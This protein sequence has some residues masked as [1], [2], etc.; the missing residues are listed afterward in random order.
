M[1]RSVLRVGMLP[2]RRYTERP[3]DELDVSG[4]VDVGGQLTAFALPSFV[5][6]SVDGNNPFAK[7]DA[8][9]RALVERDG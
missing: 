4:L 3:E 5:R 8:R 1:S 2:S 9:H 7:L 6:Q